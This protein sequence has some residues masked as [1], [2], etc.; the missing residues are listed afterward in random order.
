MQKAVENQLES[1]GAL[2]W[3]W[4]EA[5]KNFGVSIIYIVLSSKYKISAI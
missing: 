2:E 4:G 1:K 5:L 3:C